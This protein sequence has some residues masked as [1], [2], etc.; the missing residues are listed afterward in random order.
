MEISVTYAKMAEMDENE[1]Y[2]AFSTGMLCQ[3]TLLTPTKPVILHKVCYV[4][5]LLP[6]QKKSWLEQRLKEEVIDTCITPP[7]PGLLRPR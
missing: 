4:E 3:F 1:W 6:N 2:K 7:I 5:S